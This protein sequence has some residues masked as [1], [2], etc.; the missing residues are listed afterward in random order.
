MNRRQLLAAAIAAAAFHPRSGGTQPP[1]R[2]FDFNFS[3]AA[4]NVQLKPAA[5][6][7]SLELF[8]LLSDVN[9]NC[10][11]SPLSVL[12][13]MALLAEAA[14][15][16][17]RSQ[18]RGALH[19]GDEY[20]SVMR[21]AASL[22]RM[23]AAQT[24]QCRIASALYLQQGNELQSD[25]LELAQ[26]SFRAKVQPVNFQTHGHAVSGQ[27]NDWISEQTNDKIKGMFSPSSFDSL[28]SLVLVNA[29]YF[30]GTWAEQFQPRNTQP[31]PFYLANGESSKVPMMQRTGKARYAE[32][33]LLQRLELDYQGGEFAGIFLLPRL[34]KSLADLEAELAADNW[35]RW[36]TQS[37]PGIEVAMG[38]PKFKLES[39]FDLKPHL[40]RLGIVDA[41][42]QPEADF[43]GMFEPEENGLDDF[44]WLSKVAQKAFCEVNEE[45]TE[46]AA[47][48]GA[49]VARSYSA[50]PIPKRFVAERPFLFAI[51]H[52]QSGMIL[53][54]ARVNDPEKS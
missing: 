51:V 6:R 15:G 12:V 45:G 34:G 2:L 25:F 49:S 27:I 41:F 33:E 22:E 48:T 54:L 39:M 38:I 28:T 17:T 1:S 19:L 20:D 26:N 7:F 5:N 46:A 35:G 14:G 4:S 13:P 32:N 43:S 24:A 42:V 9:R 8:Q 44:V 37:R 50:R 11:A 29:I 30:K 23:R 53:F 31:S 21:L 10:I 3:F 40:Q 52:R 18:L 36:A 16:N 47:A